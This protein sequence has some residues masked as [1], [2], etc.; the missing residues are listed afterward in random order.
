VY[1]TVGLW[2]D[3]A[4]FEREVGPY[5]PGTPWEA[6]AFEVRVRERVVPG[7]VAWRRGSADLPP[8]D[9]EGVA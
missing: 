9:S 2:A 6:E 4:A 3:L 7:P 8:G 5:I 1:A